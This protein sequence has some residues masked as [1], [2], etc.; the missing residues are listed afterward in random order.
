MANRLIFLY[1]YDMRSRDE[2]AELAMWDE[3]IVELKC[4]NISLIETIKGV[5]P[6]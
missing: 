4:L 5:D 1:Y 2:E 6:Y 3:P